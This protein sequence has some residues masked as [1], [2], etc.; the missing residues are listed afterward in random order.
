MQALQDEET[1]TQLQINELNNQVYA[2]VT[3]QA[4]KDQALTVVGAAQQKLL[5]V[6]MDLEQT[7]N[8]LEALQLQGP[9]KVPAPQR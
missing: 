8:E 7:R 6:R 4:T 1:A 5:A 9:P 3:D 2:P